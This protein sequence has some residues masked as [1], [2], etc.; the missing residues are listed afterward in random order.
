MLVAAEQHLQHG[1][2][3]L[4]A[5]EAQVAA[6]AEEV[7]RA[8]GRLHK[9]LVAR[10]VGDASEADVAA[11]RTALAEAEGRLQ[12]AREVADAS[13]GALAVLQRRRDEAEQ[14]AR[15]EVAATLEAQR[16]AL[17]E[18]LGAVLVEAA[19]LNR[20]LL[21]VEDLLRQNGL[22]VPE[23]LAWGE[24]L[25]L[26]DGKVLRNKTLTFDYAVGTERCLLALWLERARRAG[27]AVHAVEPVR[28][29]E[30]VPS[31]WRR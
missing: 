2:E 1:Q 18:R 12:Q 21:A 15:E 27:Y 25:P 22:P 23:P 31:R 20:D 8:R 19:R 24:L 13:R 4:A 28:L 7:E 26:A 30:A 29:A 11:A 9:T 6:L 5:A 16:R 3:A 17:A 10:Q 14:A